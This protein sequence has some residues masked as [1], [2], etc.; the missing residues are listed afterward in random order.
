MSSTTFEELVCLVGPHVTRFPSFRKDTLVVGEILSCTLRYLASGDSMMSLVYSF[1]MGHSTISKLICECCSVL[2]QVLEKKVLLTPSV[3]NWK[4]RLEN[5]KTSGI[6]DI[7]LQR[8]MENILF[9]KLFQMM[10]HIVQFCWLCVTPIII[11]CWSIMGLREDAAMEGFS[12]VVIL[13]K[14]LPIKQYTYL[15]L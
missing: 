7:V 9:I 15:N 11:F 12:G 14:L 2:W 1:R 3:L 10:V 4:E 13:A 6:Y 8:L 5:L